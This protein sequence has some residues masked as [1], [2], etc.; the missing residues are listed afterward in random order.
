MRFKI[1]LIS[2]LV[3]GAAA[4]AVFVYSPENSGNPADIASRQTEVGEA[5]FMTYIHP[6]YGFSFDFP[7]DWGAESFAED[8]GGEVV[9]VQNAE[10]GILIFIYPF[11]EPGPIT[12][13]RVLKDVPDMKIQNEIQ[14]KIGGAIDAFGFDCDER[15]IGPTKEVWFVRNGFLYQISAAEGSGEVFYKMAETWRFN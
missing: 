5:A 12:K 4:A 15:E 7:A 13:E 11:N 8:E 14:L 10:T 1:I 3:V 9:A 6:E 2:A